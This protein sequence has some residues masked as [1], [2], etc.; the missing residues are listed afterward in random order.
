MLRLWIVLT[1][2]LFLLI[3]KHYLCTNLVVAYICLNVKPFKVFAL[4]VLKYLTWL[5]ITLQP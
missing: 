5:R 4:F 3:Q 2:D 1:N